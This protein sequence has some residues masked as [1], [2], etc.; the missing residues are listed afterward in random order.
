M[1]QHS[2]ASNLPICTDCDGFPVVA[3]ATGT[4]NPDGSR[5]TIPVTCFACKGTGRVRPALVTAGRS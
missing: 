5:V 3:I 1:P 4:L 2:H